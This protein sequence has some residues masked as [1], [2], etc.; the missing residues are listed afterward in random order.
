MGRVDRVLWDVVVLGMYVL[1]ITTCIY[2]VVLDY[3]HMLCPQ[4]FAIHYQTFEDCS[5]DMRPY[6]RYHCFKNQLTTLI[7]QQV[8]KT[9]YKRES[10]IQNN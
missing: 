2:I 7:S 6:A 8:N 4:T 9:Q 10:Q 3:W 1:C 5:T